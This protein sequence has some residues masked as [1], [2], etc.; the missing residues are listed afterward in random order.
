MYIP[1][2]VAHIVSNHT[3]RSFQCDFCEYKGISKDEIEH[4]IKND[5]DGLSFL[6]AFAQQQTAMIQNFEQFKGELTKT[7]NVIINEQN[8]Y[9]Q[10]LLKVKLNQG[11][12]DRISLLEKSIA[13]LTTEVKSALINAKTP[14]TLDAAPQNEPSMHSI[15]NSEDAK[16]S[17]HEAK[18][19]P[20]IPKPSS[21]SSPKK[22][23]S[24]QKQKSEHPN[25]IFPKL[26]RRKINVC[27]IGDSIA[28]NVD[29]KELEESTNTLITKRKLYGSVEDTVSMFPKKNLTD[30][31]PQELIR[32]FNQTGLDFD[33]L[34]IQA[35]STDITNLDTSTNAIENVEY[36]KKCATVSSQNIFNAATNALRHTDV[37]KV[38]ILER[39]PR[40]DRVK[41]DP[42]SLKSGLSEYSNGIL[43]QLW[44][45]SEFKDNI[46]IGKHDLECS[47]DVRQER[48]GNDVSFD[49]IH[50][51]GPSGQESY[52]RSI[53]NIISKSEILP[54]PRKKKESHQSSPGFDTN[55]GSRGNSPS[56]H[57]N[58][59][60]TIFK[61]SNQQKTS[62]TFSYHSKPSNSSPKAGQA[63]QHSPVFLNRGNIRDF[64]YNKNIFDL[65][66]NEN[67]SGN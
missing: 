21:A 55:L 37:K 63:K 66:N 8:F 28:H 60:Q 9:K 49:G 31:V 38:I 67:I 24:F 48:Y 57:N 25:R 19:S 56:N 16:Q 22:P 41:D 52:T 27:L 2:V 44:L 42:S 15:P 51:R 12:D 64:Y 45:Q 11:T 62:H 39:I 14:D 23:K 10:E 1:D 13:M 36:M 40:Y 43:H 34:I 54:P 7:L 6:E 4:H 18:P 58:C 46:I 50:L 29:I 59:E 61:R 53:M 65:F 3:A 33:V 47:S 26:P 35:S 32:K 20:R 30:V 17:N 5:H